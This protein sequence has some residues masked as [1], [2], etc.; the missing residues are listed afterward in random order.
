MPSLSLSRSLLLLLAMSVCS[1]S[2]GSYLPDRGRDFLDCFT[3]TLSAG[4]EISADVQ[5]TDLL[6]LSVGGGVHGEAGMIGRRFG[7]A[8][9]MTLGLPVAPFM[10]D[11]VLHGR[12]LFSDAQGGWREQDVQDEC[13]LIHLGGWA[14]TNPQSSWVHGFDL[15]IGAH[16]LVGA[17]LGLSPGQMVDFLA[18]V[19]GF[20][21]AG[22]D[23]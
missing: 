12:F 21:P 5:A 23:S 13:Y 10:E 16:V 4:P 3:M 15:E 11:G 1:C 8:G 7:S 20:D 2:S 17:R 22:D 6:H 19:I 9:V 14:P 18:G